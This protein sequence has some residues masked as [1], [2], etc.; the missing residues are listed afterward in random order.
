LELID[1]TRQTIRKPGSEECKN[2]RT[3]NHRSQTSNC[4]ETS[5][6]QCCSVCTYASTISAQRQSP[7]G[8]RPHDPE[9]CS[10]TWTN[11]T[12]CGCASG[13]SIQTSLCS[14]S[15]NLRRSCSDHCNQPDK[16]GARG[17]GE[18]TISFDQWFIRKQAQAYCGSIIE[19]TN[20]F[21]STA[22]ET[23]ASASTETSTSTKLVDI[24][25]GEKK[26]CI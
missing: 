6:S 15:A 5:R 11:K 10:E 22:T 12:T 18:E 9:L 21:I 20:N 7:R 2:N 17:Q 3:N 4:T 25:I 23:I 14:R 13:S 8:T 16:A 1:T 19:Q 26:T 24:Y